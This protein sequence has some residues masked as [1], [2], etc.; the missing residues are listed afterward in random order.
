MNS[1]VHTG[2]LSSKCDPGRT[3]SIRTNAAVLCCLPS[4]L[5]TLCRAVPLCLLRS[6]QVLC[7][8][9]GS[10]LPLHGLATRR[11]QPTL[12]HIRCMAP[13]DC[14]LHLPTRRTCHP[15]RLELRGSCQQI[16]PQ[17]VLGRTT[18]LKDQTVRRPRPQ[19]VGSQALEAL[20]VP[21]RPQTAISQPIRSQEA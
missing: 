16:P 8:L 3:G 13:V 4:C 12:Q 6:A 19:P 1:V 11:L 7:H 10:Q 2:D 15:Q 17:W 21:R 14:Q 20:D 5:T 18:C 9:T